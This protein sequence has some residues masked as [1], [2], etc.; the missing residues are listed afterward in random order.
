MKTKVVITVDTEPSI[1]GAFAPSKRYKPRI[2]EPVWGE[3][4]GISEALGF[5]LDTLVHHEL[6]ATFF[7]E[8]VHLAH[9]P[10]HI[11]GGYVHHIR[12]AEQDVQLHLHP[13]WQRFEPGFESGND[14][15]TDRC[16]E[17]SDQHLVNLIT[18]GCE[19]IRHWTG[20]NPSSLRTGNFSTSASVYRAMKA[21]GLEISSNICVAVSRPAE[22]S[23][24]HW[25]EPV[26]LAGG[27]HEIEGIIEL[28]V[29]CFEDRAPTA[30][31][32]LRP[33]QVTACGFAE[34]RAQLTALHRAG[35][36]TAVIVTHPFEFLR[37]SGPGFSNLRANRLVQARF[38]KLCRFL[39]RNT[40]KFEVVPI[41][42]FAEAAIE[43][44][45]GLNGS[46]IS[47]TIRAVANFTNDRL[48]LSPFATW[49]T[50]T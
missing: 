40:D 9:F 11:M 27:I 18:T 36:S 32:K 47:S 45:V 19:R 31:G 17:L 23:A 44:A 7:V 10:E 4:S 25:G 42:R 2:H 15:L 22:A 12:E 33:L 50:K 37:W 21:A 20:E 14:Q 16:G 35:S 43:P 41:S 1:A 5:M 49:W 39:A 38:R 46:A 30:R 29:T 8:T 13:V 28:P 6:C 26:N 3:V 34:M 24:E 48:P